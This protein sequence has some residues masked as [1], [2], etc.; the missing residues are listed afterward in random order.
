MQQLACLPSLIRHDSVR[1][2][3]RK[4]ELVMGSRQRRTASALLIA[5]LPIQPRL[6]T[7]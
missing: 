1:S 5:V 4:E 3:D 2:L 6:P 7:G